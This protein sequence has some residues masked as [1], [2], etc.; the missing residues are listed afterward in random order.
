MHFDDRLGTVLRLR[1]D[2]KAVQ[3]IQ[4]RQL[5][6]LLGTSPAEARGQALDAAY[7]RLI[8]LAA[9]IPSSERAA[10]VG[11]PGLRLRSPRLVA[12]LAAGEPQVAA[13]TLRRAELSDEQWLDLVPA[14]PPAARVHLRDRRGLSLAVTNLLSRLG[15]N[16]RG[17]PPVSEAVAAVQ[18]EAEAA[19]VP[20]SDVLPPLPDSTENAGIGAIV[21]R[22]EAYRKAKQVVEHTPPGDSPRLPLGE[23]HILHVPAE[24]R[25][26]DFATNAEGR[27]AWADPGVAPMVTGLRLGGEQARGGGIDIALRR[28]Q[29]LQDSAI[30]L[31][32]APAIAGDWRLDAAPWFD[33]LSG[34]YLGHRGRMRRIPEHFSA[35]AAPIAANPPVRDSE[36]DRIRQMLHELRTPVNAIQVGAEIIQQQL[37]GPTP[38]EYR[39]LAAGIASDA[40]RMLSAFE[41]LER[42][43]RLDSQAMELDRGESDLVAVVSATAAQLADHTRQRGSGFAL[44]IEDQPMPVALAQIEVERVVWRLLATL[45]G[46]SAPGEVL[47]ARLR[48]RQGMVRLD[49]DLPATLAA[50]EG[51]TLF[52]A[53]AGSIPQVISAGVFGVGFALR[54]A[55]AEAKAAGGKLDRKGDRLRLSL[56]GLTQDSGNHTHT[57]RTA[58]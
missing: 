13:A 32:G 5:L 52:H 34:R 28:H 8:E 7:V 54:L 3:R 57:R 35:I 22:I 26:F 9:T 24:V 16:D 33:P 31:D 19:P 50:R 20:G 23:E 49:L 10:M 42:L 38:H 46:V 44:R 1:A 53:A 14:L 17:L 4:F 40:A 12:A 29:P 39:A 27:I 37:Y 47:K 55:R 30:T 48:R 15:V 2:G 45:A 36:A 25:A 51:D 41:E 56:P 58:D 18:A 6:D 11:D 21:R 43:A